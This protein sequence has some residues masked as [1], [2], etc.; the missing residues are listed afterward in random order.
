MSFCFLSIVLFFGCLIGSIVQADDRYVELPPSAGLKWADKIQ[1]MELFSY[2]CGHCYSL[3]PVIQPWVD[4]LPGDVNFLQMPAMFGGIW[5][6]YGQLFLTLQA[7]NVSPDVHAAVFEAI[8]NRQRLSTP[9]AMAEF[10]AT[11]GVEQQQFLGTYHSFFVQAKV[12]DAIRITEL[13]G[14]SGVPA[15]VVNG[16]YRFD[17]SAGGPR[18]MLELA[19][20]LI[21]KERSGR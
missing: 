9:E 17:Q 13:S 19:E 15:L 5:N 14:V 12:K 21:A 11:Q 4:R 8:H 18:G 7:M 2:G 3:E 20:E 16:Q 10:L 1:V 6:V